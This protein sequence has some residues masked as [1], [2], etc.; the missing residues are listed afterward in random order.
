MAKKPNGECQL[1][2]PLKKTFITITMTQQKS[3]FSPF[4]WI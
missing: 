2:I 3:F 4:L 1:E